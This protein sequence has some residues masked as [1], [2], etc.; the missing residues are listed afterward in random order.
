MIFIIFNKITF[1]QF[2]KLDWKFLEAHL[3]IFKSSIANIIC[4]MISTEAS[5][6]NIL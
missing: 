5:W 6:W 1:R 3:Y 2:H 4:L